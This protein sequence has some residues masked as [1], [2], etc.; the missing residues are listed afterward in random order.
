MSAPG[1][2]RAPEIDHPPVS[3]ITPVFNGAPYLDAYFGPYRSAP[4]GRFELIVVDNGS[5][6][7]T[8]EV[9]ESLK[10][11]LPFLRVFS[12]TERRSS[13]AARNFGA[14]RAQ[15]RL[16]A[17]TDFDC[18]VSP[19]YT[20]ILQELADGPLHSLTSGTV[21]LFY[22][23]RNTFE[24]FDHHAYLDQESY[25]ARGR[26]A[27]ANLAVPAGIFRRLGG[28]AP[29]TS[30]ADVDFCDRARSIGVRLEYRPELRVLH[31]PRDTAAAHIE[32]ASRIGTGLG[33]LFR[34]SR[35]GIARRTVFAATQLANLAVP[36]FQL[37]IFRRIVR[38]ERLDLAQ[39]IRLLILCYR[40]GWAARLAMLPYAFRPT[41][42]DL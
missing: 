37:G 35:L 15:G 19:D 13:Y 41:E 33:E 21:E 4:T 2:P 1:Q 7:G 12:Y 27:T 16:L 9:L 20:R 10:A 42:E 6:D 38:A 32:K 22:R 18:I 36:R 14:S 5:D 29:V 23:T 3:I 34:N 28:F 40:V 17:F 26:G 31:P 24:V 11:E 8:L 39:R 25:A 30:G